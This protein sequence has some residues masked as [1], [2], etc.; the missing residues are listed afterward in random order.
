MESKKAQAITYSKESQS[1]KV[2]SIK[3]SFMA[4]VSLRTLKRILNIKVILYTEKS[5]GKG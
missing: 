2:S 1:M 4:T 5:R 3:T